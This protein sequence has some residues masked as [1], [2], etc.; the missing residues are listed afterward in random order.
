[1]TTGAEKLGVNKTPATVS[2]TASKATPTAAQ[3]KQLEAEEARFAFG[4]VER[5]AILSDSA[6]VRGAITAIQWLLRSKAQMKAFRVDH[7]TQALQ[8][9]HERE[10]FDLAEAETTARAVMA[11]TN[12]AY[13]ANG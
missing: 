13:R 4:N 12:A 2:F 5:N 9:L 8:W 6:V 1:M 10:P 3:R 7:V 11:A